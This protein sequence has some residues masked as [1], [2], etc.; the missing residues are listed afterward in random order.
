MN[1]IR[2]TI[3]YLFCNFFA[4]MLIWLPYFF[5]GCTKKTDVQIPSYIEI[6][7]YFTKVVPASVGCYQGTNNQNFTD[8]LVYANG[9]SYGTY[10]M[11]SKI[12]VLTSGPTSFIIRGVIRVNGVDAL[13]SDYE[14]MKGCD[15]LITVNPGKITHVIPVFEYFSA[16]QFPWMVTFDA[17]PDSG[18]H[19]PTL[20]ASCNCHTSTAIT[21]SPG[22]GNTGYCLALK[23][24]S[25]S[26]IVSVQT[27]SAIPLPAGGVGVYM[28]LNYLANTDIHVIINNTDGGIIKASPDSGWKK[29]YLTLTEQVSS[30]QATTGYTVAFQAYYNP[31]VGANLALIDNIKIVTAR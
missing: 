9:T 25:D 24:T 2:R 13:R 6:D 23:P 27:Q 19:G 12:P 21:Y 7:N 8:V 30:L 20:V 10:P 16:A 17:Q 31:M 28:E 15:T 3:N 14:V 26:T 11:G 5:L 22:Y 1:E 18:N 29:I 4:I